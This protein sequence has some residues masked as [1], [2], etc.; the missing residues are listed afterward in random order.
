V[1]TAESL[2]PSSRSLCRQ[3]Q[4]SLIFA[5]PVAVV[6]QGTTLLGKKTAHLG[7]SPRWRRLSSPQQSV[8]IKCSKVITKLLSSLL[9]MKKLKPKQAGSPKKCPSLPAPSPS[10]T[11]L[12]A[13]GGQESWIKQ[14]IFCTDSHC[15]TAND[16]KD[17]TTSG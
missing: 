16:G 12:P 8:Q 2:L 5:A 10:H 9:A 15:S 3:M 4:A 17:Q 11:L 1:P 14:Q 6:Q 7:R 13:E